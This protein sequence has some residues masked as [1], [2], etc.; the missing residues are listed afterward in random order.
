MSLIEGKVHQ[1]NTEL[2]LL[3]IAMHDFHNENIVFKELESRPQIF[4]GVGLDRVTVRFVDVL[5]TE[6]SLRSDD[7]VSLLPFLEIF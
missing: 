1:R 3:M 6:Q 4:D 2:S 5:V 7:C